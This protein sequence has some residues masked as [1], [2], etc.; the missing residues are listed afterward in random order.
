[1]QTILFLFLLF[2][3]VSFSILLYLKTKTSRLD[4]LNKGECPSC[5][6]K[7]K[8]FFDTKTNTK[9]KY[10]II[11]TRLLKD[12]GCSGV[13]EIE[14]VCKSCGLKEVHSIN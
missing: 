13:K 7:T 11:T 12:H 3:I 14:Y 4:K 5:H 9:F 6:Q 1:M 2:L 8:E 10:E